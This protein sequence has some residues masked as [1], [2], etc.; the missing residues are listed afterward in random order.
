[1]LFLLHAGAH[2]G[3]S[4]QIENGV[5]Q[6]A[7]NKYHITLLSAMF[8]FS[9]NAVEMQPDEDS[10]LKTLC[11]IFEGV[12]LDAKHFRTHCWLPRMHKMSEEKT[13]ETG[14]N[15]INFAANEF[16]N[17]YGFIIHRANYL[18][19]NCLVLKWCN[20]F[21]ISFQAKTFARTLKNPKTF[22]FCLE[23]QTF[24]KYVN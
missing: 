22:L 14:D 15:L 6:C 17:K 9:V 11:R 20:P 2:I 12:V 16:I 21:F 23:K 8:V 7:V 19:K 5:S 13:I 4:N 10:I 1:M 24:R 18:T 3:Y